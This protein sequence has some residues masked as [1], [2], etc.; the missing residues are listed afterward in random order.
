M[1]SRAAISHSAMLIFAGSNCGGDLRASAKA[2]GQRYFSMF[3]S[4]AGSID[5]SPSDAGTLNRAAL[6]ER[7]SSETG[8][9]VNSALGQGSKNRLSVS[10]DVVVRLLLKTLGRVKLCP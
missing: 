2:C 10:N 7:R 9:Y 4:Q 6:L 8:S 5:W 1:V 3:N